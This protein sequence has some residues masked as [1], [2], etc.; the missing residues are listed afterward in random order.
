MKTEIDHGMR[1]ENANLQ[2]IVLVVELRV[3][4]LH[5]KSRGAKKTLGD[6]RSVVNE[7]LQ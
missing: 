6:I 4:Y 7:E 2:G 1:T 5:L 3:Q